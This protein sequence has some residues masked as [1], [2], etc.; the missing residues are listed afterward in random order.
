MA[1]VRPVTKTLI[2]V[3]NWGV[4]IT[5]EVNRLTDLTTSNV[6]T[7][8]TT[9]TLINGWV[10]DTNNAVQYR[11]V[12]DMLQ[13]RGRCKNGTWGF[14]DLFTLPVG[15]RP[16]REAHLSVGIVLSAASWSTSVCFIYATGAVGGGG[17]TAV[18]DYSFSNSISLAP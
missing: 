13:L 11:K 5:D 7:A 12:G 6:P 8:W 16:I 10:H 2:S 14:A 17:S 1:I 9:V 3:P 15:F 4:P 18:T